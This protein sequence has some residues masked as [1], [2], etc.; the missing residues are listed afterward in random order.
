MNITN[1]LFKFNIEDSRK[2]IFAGYI[3]DISDEILNMIT[4]LPDIQKNIIIN[5]INFFSSIN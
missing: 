4:I 1:Q 3:D 2:Y 5:R